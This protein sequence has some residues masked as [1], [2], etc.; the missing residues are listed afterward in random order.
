M[1]SPYQAVKRTS[2]AEDIVEQIEKL[3]LNKELQVGDPLPS[4]RE[5]ARELQVSRQALREAM[6]ILVQK[7]LVQVQPGRGAFVAQPS[8]NFLSDSLYAYLRLNPHLVRDF[9]EA[10]RVIETEAA[11]MAAE[12]ATPEHLVAIKKALDDLEAYRIELLPR[13]TAGMANRSTSG[14]G[15]TG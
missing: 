4:E 5:L 3:V 15:R 7:G 6:R 11:A 12:R 2:L 14:S 8:A 10:R 1:P 9:L 13:L